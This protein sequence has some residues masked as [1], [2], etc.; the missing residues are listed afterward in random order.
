[1]VSNNMQLDRKTSIQK[2][3]IHTDTAMC[4]SYPFNHKASNVVIIETIIGHIT[5]FKTV[6]TKAKFSKE[7]YSIPLVVILGS[8][9]S[10][11]NVMK[12]LFFNSLHICVVS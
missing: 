1:M 4:Y 11:E 10:P 9:F 5:D 3:V 2:Y 12:D 8:K 6:L 7:K